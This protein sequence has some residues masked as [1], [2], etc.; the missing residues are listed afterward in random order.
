MHPGATLFLDVGVQVDLWPDGSWPVMRAESAHNVAVLFA[1]AGDLGVRQGGVVCR[2]DVTS[3][4]APA[5]GVPAH[6]A[7][8]EAGRTRPEGGRPALPIRIVTADDVHGDQALDRA[9]AIYVDSGCGAAPD[10]GPR[11]RAFAHLANGVRDA[12]VFGAGVEYGV[13][14]A[15]SALLRR[16]VRVH[17]ALD[18][19]GAVDEEAG[20][21]VVAAWKRRGVDGTTIAM[22]A[23][24]LRR[25]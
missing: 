21:L 8:A 14:R 24:A 15:V 12:V 6:C 3:D 18:A 17:V 1:L 23:R 2:H 5:V 11:A 7:Y 13:D 4:A 9:H 19:V 10:D 16:R 22:I 25:G 20:Q